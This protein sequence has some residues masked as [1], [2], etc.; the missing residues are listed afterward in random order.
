MISN[1]IYTSRHFAYSLN[2]INKPLE[3][4]EEG[5]TSVDILFVA[6]TS[7]FNDSFIYLSR[8]FAHSFNNFIDKYGF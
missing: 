7:L 4:N 6:S 8:H 3:E 1:I 5:S 2:P